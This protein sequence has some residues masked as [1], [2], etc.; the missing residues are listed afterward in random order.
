[1]SSYKHL[2]SGIESYIV[3]SLFCTYFRHYTYRKTKKFC[4][5]S[6]NVI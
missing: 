5:G 2:K 6:C 4:L 3:P 1:M